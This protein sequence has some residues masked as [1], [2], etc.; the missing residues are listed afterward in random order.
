MK[1]KA[2]T[3]I[4]L[5]I[6]IAIIAIL[7]AIVFVALDPLSR[8]QDARNSR[9]WADANALLSAIHI[10][11][12]DSGGN[13]LAAITSTTAGQVYMIGTATTSCNTGCTLIVATSTNCV[14]LTGLV[15]GGYLGSLPISPNG[16]GS[17]TS[18]ITGYTLS[19]NSTMGGVTIKACEGEHNLTPGQISVAR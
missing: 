14:D 18:A 11:Q 7:A 8:F 3:L 10:Q 9:R 5:L 17:W 15:S 4:E 6:V 1:K 2:F 16:V 13:L 19:R 12:I